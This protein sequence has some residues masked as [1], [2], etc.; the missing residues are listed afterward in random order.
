MKVTVHHFVAST[1]T[2][3]YGTHTSDLLGVDYWREVPSDTE[4]PKTIIRMDLFTR[5][6]LER[7][8][9]TEFFVKIWWIDHPSGDPELIGSFGPFRVN[10]QRDQIVRDYSFHLHN[11]RLQ[12][13]G[14]HM[15]ELQREVNRK[16]RR[17][18]LATIARTHFMVER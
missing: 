7:A 18:D 15:I 2:R 13:V 12:G 11:V 4:F 8:K 16:W 10:F 17:N 3:Q 6:Y 1:V 5:F 9:A 14:R